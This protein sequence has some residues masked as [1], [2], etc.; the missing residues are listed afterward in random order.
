ME[1]GGKCAA[2]AGLAPS[3][4]CMVG[5]HCKV[6]SNGKD[7]GVW[8]AAAPLTLLLTV[9]LWRKQQAQHGTSAAGNAE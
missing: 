9:F 6:G 7:A 2:P 3:P 4:S 1:Q 8:W 5:L